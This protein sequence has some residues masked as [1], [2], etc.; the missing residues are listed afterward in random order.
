MN[1]QPDQQ[2]GGLPG[3]PDFVPYNPYAAPTQQGVPLPPLPSPPSPPM[4]QAAP[5]NYGAAGGLLRPLALNEILDR[6]FALYRLHASRFLAIL[7]VAYIPF[8]LVNTVLT[9][10][11]ARFSNELGLNDSQFATRDDA[12]SQLGRLYAGLGFYLLLTLALGLMLQLAAATLIKAVADSY[13]GETPSIGQAYRYMAGRFGSLLGWLGL[14]FLGLMLAG[15]LILCLFAGP[16]AAFFLAPFYLV[17]LQVLV[18]ERRGP[19]AAFSRSYQL[20]R[21]GGWGRSLGLWLLTILLS[22]LLTGGLGQL[23][24]FLTQTF[25][26]ALDAASVQG[27]TTIVGGVIGYLLEPVSVIAFTLFYIDLRVRNEGYD[28]EVALNRLREPQ[29]A[30]DKQAL[31]GV[32]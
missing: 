5:L 8:I 16:V 29:K 18:L 30:S 23:V 12:L 22:M 32:R 14:L 17:S 27:V 20:V 28:F 7:G 24:G 10:W 4:Q 9:T 2:A 6:S 31:V 1:E 13:M 19:I 21:N 15:I 3:R 25:L 11:F 26:P